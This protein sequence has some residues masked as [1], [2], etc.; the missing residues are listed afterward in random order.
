MALKGDRQ[1]I[2][3]DVTFFS[4]GTGAK[5][6]VVCLTGVGSGAALD[7]SAAVV[8]VV[9][10]ASGMKPMGI[11]LQDIVNKDLTQTHLNFYK[12]EVQTGAKVCFI[13]KGWVVTDA[14]S[15]TP[16]LFDNAYLAANGK[17]TPT[18]V[19]SGASPRVGTFLSTKDA[20][21]YAKVD[22]N[23]PV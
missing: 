18:F 4:S 15:G 2:Y 11:L 3:D 5:G 22:V 1:I 9:S 14:I 12:E 21:G 16:G 20:D 7:Q 13:K 10:T 23:L 6:Y 8:A 17:V 19:S